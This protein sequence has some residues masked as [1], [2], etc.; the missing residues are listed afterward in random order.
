M[1][2]N[3]AATAAR[4]AVAPLHSVFAFAAH[5]TVLSIFL[6]IFGC[7]LIQL[8]FGFKIKTTEHKSESK[9]RISGP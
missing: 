6:R 1:L 5:I 3:A 4:V 2:P 8:L 9:C 7:V